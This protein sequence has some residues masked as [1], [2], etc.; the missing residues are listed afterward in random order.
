MAKGHGST[1]RINFIFS[2][3]VIFKNGQIQNNASGRFPINV[4]TNNPLTIFNKTLCIQPVLPATASFLFKQL[5]F[6]S[7]RGRYFVSCDE[8]R[9]YRDCFIPDWSR[10]QFR[11]LFERNDCIVHRLLSDVIFV[12]CSEVQG[13]RLEKGIRNMCQALDNKGEDCVS[14]VFYNL[15]N[16]W[17]QYIGFFVDMSCYK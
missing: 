2:L 3:P 12:M 1:L 13:K 9:Y 15:H 10:C 7:Y 6:S 14:V 17:I 5:I 4:K 16:I 8:E 11:A